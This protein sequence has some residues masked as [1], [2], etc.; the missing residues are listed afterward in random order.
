MTHHSS[1]ECIDEFTIVNQRGKDMIKSMVRNAGVLVIALSIA[2]W[3]ENWPQWR[4]IANS[5]VSAEKDLPTE[6]SATENVAWKTA[7]PGRG[8]SSPVVWGNHVF[9]TTAVEGSAVEGHKPPLH[10]I[11][12]QVFR[13]PDSLG[14]DHEWTL[15]LLALDA[16][17]GKILWQRT[18]YQG[19]VYDERHKKNTYASPT[20]V[21]DGKH[22]FVSFESQGIYA[23]DFNGKPLWKSSVGN[24]GTLGIGPATSPVISRDRVILL[25]DQEEGEGSFICALSARNGEMLWKVDRKGEPAN[26][27][28][29]LIIG[30][31][32]VVSGMMNVISYD[33]Q[34]GKELWRTKGVEGN[35]VPSP[36]TGFDMVFASAGYPTK[37]AY[38]IRLTG[39]GD[40]IAWQYDKGT[41]YVPSPV[42]YGD[43]LYLMTDRGLVTCLEAKTGKLVYEG[44]RPPKPATFSASA[45]AFSGRVFLTSEDGDTY[46]IKAGPE[47][48]ILATNSL[49]EPVY[50]TPA[51]SNG[52]IF[53]RTTSNLYCIRAAAE[54]VKRN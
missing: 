3:A 43:Y 36:V 37:R 18:A 52:R 7:L 54:G 44:K 8:H 41:A 23:Y 22:V 45:L 25:F 40:R 51:I 13:H 20:P 4:G 31:Q 2:S 38:G 30:D 1:G 16:K 32:V 33:T 29:P 34:T 50:A 17:S 28:T 49:G 39:D 48:E 24:I 53:I 42:L 10:K 35:A 5:G 46:V 27:T 19:P 47:H 26:W 9:L 12:G 15:S 6:W 14:M 21:T 11:E